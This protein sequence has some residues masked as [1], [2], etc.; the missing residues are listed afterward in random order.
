MAHYAFLENNI[1]TEVIVGNDEAT[2]DWETHYAK[3]RGQVCK[4]TSYNTVGGVHILGG[5]P[6]RKNYAGIGYSYDENLDAFIPPKEFVSWSLNTT[7]C[8]WESPTPYPSDG[9]P[10]EWNET[11]QAW[12]EFL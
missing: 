6:F 2:G 11:T 9:K 5:I 7:T 4:Q 12:V 3:V 10:Y 1:V 8:Q